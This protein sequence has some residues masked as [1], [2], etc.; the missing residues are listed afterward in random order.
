MG[1]PSGVCTLRRQTSGS[2]GP[3]GLSR[4]LL[5][6]PGFIFTRSL[7]LPKGFIGIVPGLRN[8]RRLK[9]CL[10]SLPVPQPMRAGA[11][12]FIARRTPSAMRRATNA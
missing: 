9:T 4:S 7:V 2:V 12:L 8:Q 10:G 5:A 6:R 3:A 1:R 11:R